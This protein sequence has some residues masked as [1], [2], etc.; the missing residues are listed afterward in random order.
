MAKTSKK[1]TKTEA[2]IVDKR[3]ALSR[4]IQNW[5]GVQL[6]YTPHA[7]NL[8]AAKGTLD[9]NGVLQLGNPENIP[10]FLPS[11]MPP[12]IRSTTE[13]KKICEMELSLRKAA[14]DDALCEIRKGRRNLMKLWKYKKINVSGTGNRPNTRMLTVYKRMDYKIER[15]AHKYRRSRTALL[16]LDPDGAWKENLK[17]LRNE[18]IRGPGKDPDDTK[19]SNGRYDESWIWMVQKN[20]AVAENEEREFID[21]MRVEWV[22]SR[23]RSMR[24]EEEFLLLQ[25]EMRRVLVW[26]QWKAAWWEAQALLRTS[27]PPDILSGIEAYSHKQGHILLRMAEQSAVEWLPVLREEGCEPDWPSHFLSLPTPKEK[28][29]RGRGRQQVGENGAD[30]SEEDS[31]REL[32]NTSDEDEEERAHD[33]GENDNDDDDVLDFDF[34]DY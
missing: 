18:D 33:D 20:E 30:E 22:K 26:S 32:L 3:T 8:I 29:G 6:V 21:D 2:D 31:E 28:K 17:E 27:A 23:A 10:L 19:T 12:E 4:R 14:A 7:A 34:D 25:E 11:A 24:W 13:M 9:E 5:R 1:T 16:A 15:A